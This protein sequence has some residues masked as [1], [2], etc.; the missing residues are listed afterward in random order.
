[1]CVVLCNISLQA[2]L[3]SWSRGGGRHIGWLCQGTELEVSLS[4]CLFVCL[5]YLYIVQETHCEY[6]GRSSGGGQ[7]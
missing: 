1:M 7:T 2:D 6:G 4:V 5:Y 3:H